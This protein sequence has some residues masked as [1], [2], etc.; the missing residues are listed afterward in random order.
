MQSKRQG[1]DSSGPVKKRTTI[2]KITQTI[3]SGKGLILIGI[4]I[5]VSGIFATQA[6]NWTPIQATITESYVHRWKGGEGGGGSSARISWEYTVDSVDY[7]AW[8]YEGFTISIDVIINIFR[9]SGS[10]ELVEKHPVGSTVTVYYNPTNP[11]QSFL[12][13][14]WIFLGI[15]WPSWILLLIGGVFLSIGIFIVVGIKTGRIKKPE[16]ERYQN[17]YAG[18]NGSTQ[19]GS[20][21]SMKRSKNDQV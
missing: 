10:E 16:Q 4:I 7:T 13:R 1:R 20:S 19:M 11:K 17:Q 9:G 21:G 18:A 15:E 3:T 2:Q 6:E 8:N 12:S 14:G 5:I